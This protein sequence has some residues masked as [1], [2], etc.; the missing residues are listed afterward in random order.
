M[1]VAGKYCSTAPTGDTCLVGGV[2]KKCL[3]F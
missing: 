1:S 3:F 2:V